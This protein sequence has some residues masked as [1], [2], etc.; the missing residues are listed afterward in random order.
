MGR[1]SIRGNSV[2]VYITPHERYEVMKVYADKLS[3]A[4][5]EQ[6]EEAPESAIVRLEWGF[7]NRPTVV[8]IIE[9]G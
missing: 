4:Q 6:I 7:D 8:T 9:E 5:L 1:T 2:A 3:S